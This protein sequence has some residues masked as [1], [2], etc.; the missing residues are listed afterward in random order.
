[1]RGWNAKKFRK[2]VNSVAIG[3]APLNGQVVSSTKSDIR[4]KI[5]EAVNYSEGT[6]RS[7]ESPTSSGPSEPSVVEKLE[8]MFGTSFDANQATSNTNNRKGNNTM[9]NQVA[10][11]DFI[12]KQLFEV[13]SLIKNYIGNADVEEEEK[14]VEL[15][16]ELERYSI[17]IPEE[18][19]D[20][21][22]D[23]VDTK[24][25]PM[26]YDNAS[27]FSEC[28]TSDIGCHEDDG[29]FTTNSDEGTLKMIGAFYDVI[30]RTEQD[31]DKIA[32][33]HIRP[34]LLA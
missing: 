33:E 10:V 7:W 26:V 2:L 8:A 13:Y 28:Y 11:N 29:T 22:I 27:V 6:V 15:Q 31:F 34:I 24:L 9:M 12:K 4:I 20:I 16:S 5:A 32:D 21:L 19:Y 23:F 17:S 18:V 25:A 14:F 1:M 3:V 30:M